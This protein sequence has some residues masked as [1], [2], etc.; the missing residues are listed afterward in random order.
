MVIS[1]SETGNR[2]EDDGFVVV[3][4]YGRRQMLGSSLVISVSC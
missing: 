4:E 1:I 3:E 2:R